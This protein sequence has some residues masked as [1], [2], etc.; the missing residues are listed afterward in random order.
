MS[1]WL[2]NAFWVDN[3][4]TAV[5]AI[6]ETDLGGGKVDRNVH[7][8]TKTADDGTENVLWAQFFEQVSAEKV[9]RNTKE[10]HD[11]KAKEHALETQK[12]E[13]TLRAR[14]LEAL[15]DA[16]LKAFEIQDIKDSKNRKLKA[17]LRKAKNMVEV[18]AF[19]TM[20]IMEQV[21][22]ESEEQ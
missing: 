17:R 3:S 15:F 14:Q 4:K 7:T 11:R 5:K 9:D 10:R 18:N 16:K 19:A 12:R 6:L 13:E 22:N 20:I 1:K 8:I 2:D 21:N